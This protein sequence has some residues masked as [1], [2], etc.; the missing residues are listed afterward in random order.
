MLLAFDTSSD[1]CSVAIYKNEE[2]LD[3]IIE[4]TIHK[5][6]ELLIMM[7]A[8]SLKYV[9]SSYEDLTHIACAIGPG[10]FTG[11]RV[12]MAAAHGIALCLP[13]VKL[14]GVS[15]LEAMAWLDNKKDCHAILKAGRDQFYSQ[16]FLDKIA[17]SEV[18]L[19]I[20][21]EVKSS[22]GMYDEAVL[23]IREIERCSYKAPNAIGVALAAQSRVINNNINNIEPLYVREPSIR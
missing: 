15:S 13:K 10:S 7:I 18:R 2:L 19:V 20:Q 12:G 21:E 17:V 16:I 5:Q 3:Y 14:I 22:A 23:G 8:H 1:Y 9:K 6:A 4:E 11:I